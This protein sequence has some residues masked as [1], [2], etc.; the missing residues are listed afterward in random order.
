MTSRANRIG[1]N[2]AQSPLAESA[3][4]SVD[5]A[6][7]GRD[8]GERIDGGSVGREG[9]INVDSEKRMCGQRR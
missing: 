3:K 7:P 4:M 9:E 5:G 2:V 6:G 1:E 8:I